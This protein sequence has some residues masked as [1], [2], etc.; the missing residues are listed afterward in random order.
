VYKEIIID[1]Q[2]NGAF[3]PATMGRKKKEEKNE[4]NIKMKEKENIEFRYASKQKTDP[5]Y[6]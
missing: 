5:E 3:D 1:C 4:R 2:K 6:E